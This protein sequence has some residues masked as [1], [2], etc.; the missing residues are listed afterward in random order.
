MDA[1]MMGRKEG[2]DGWFD[3]AWLEFVGI[4]GWLAS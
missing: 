1:R 3:L 2:V 4:I